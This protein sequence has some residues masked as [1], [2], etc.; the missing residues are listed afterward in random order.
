LR[1]KIVD[2]LM[3]LESGT[4]E[5]HEICQEAQ[6]I[7]EQYA[8]DQIEEIHGNAQVMRDLNTNDD[9]QFISMEE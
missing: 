7:Y 9:D 2:D 5:F 4:K 1:D 3:E 8:T 6:S